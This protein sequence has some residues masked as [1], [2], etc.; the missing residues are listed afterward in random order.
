MKT[1]RKQNKQI[2]VIVGLVIRNGKIL[3]VKRHEPEVVD[4][5]LK[6][7]YPGGKVE[8]AE[9]P[10]QAIIREVQEETGVIVKVKRLLPCVYTHYWE[11]NSGTQQTL[12]FGYECEYVG[13]SERVADHHVSTVKWFPLSELAHLE[14]LP[15]GKEFFDSL[16][17]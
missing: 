14:T 7:E 2:T 13:E 5:H 17:A 9:T 12:L 10:E 8:F 3:L 11:Y 16:S 1:P 6:W 15:G 4:A